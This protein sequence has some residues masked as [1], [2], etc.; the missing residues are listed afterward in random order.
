MTGVEDVW[1]GPSVVAII[2]DWH[3]NVQWALAVLDDMAA[4]KIPLGIHLGDFGIWPGPQGKRYLDVV[5]RRCAR[6]G[7]TLWVVPGNHEDYKQISSGKTDLLGRRVFRPHILGLPRGYR[8]PWHG[9]TWLALGGAVSVDRVERIPGRSW[10]P[11]EEI[12]E[13]E[14]DKV[15]ADG[16]ADV[17]VTHDVPAGVVH[18]FGPQP[19]RW[20]GD[21]VRTERHRMRLQRVVDGVQPSYLMHGHLHRPYERWTEMEHGSVRVTGFDCD[22]AWHGNWAPLDVRTMQWLAPEGDF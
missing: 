18:A 12:T 8:W 6:L 13:G 3:G 21:I 5:E 9:R 4:R 1:R 19:A 16:L 15:I 22:G 20:Q 11:E 7:I 14:A 10:W 2:G 17:M